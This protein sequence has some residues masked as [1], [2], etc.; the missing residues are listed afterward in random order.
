MTSCEPLRVAQAPL[1][2]LLLAND[3]VV[4]CTGGGVPVRLDSAGREQGV[5]AAVDKDLASA[6][7]A[8]EL[9]ADLL[10]LLTDG[11][12]VTK[13]WGKD[14]QRSIL[15][16]NSEELSKFEFEEGSMKPKVDAAM[17]VADAGDRVLI[18]PLDQLDELIARKI[19]TEV[20][21][22]VEGGIFWAD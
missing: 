10:I 14:S 17:R 5:Q 21:N 4:V 6:A 12:Y 15:A 16:A 8:A 20:S 3:K 11:G 1:I 13:D 19:G 9:K 7:L 22:D 2:D 18:G